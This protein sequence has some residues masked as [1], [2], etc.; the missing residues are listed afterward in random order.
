M[1]IRSIKYRLNNTQFVRIQ[2]LVKHPESEEMRES[3]FT[4][5]RVRLNKDADKLLDSDF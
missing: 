1:M 4:N 3:K 5:Y 2:A